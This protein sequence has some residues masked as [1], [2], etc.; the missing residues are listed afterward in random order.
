MSSDIEQATEAEKEKLENQAVGDALRNLTLNELA[1]LPLVEYERCRIEKAKTLGMRVRVLDEEVEQRKPK[2][3]SSATHQEGRSILLSDP[4]PWPDTVNLES[5]LDSILA[6]IRRFLILPKS[7]AVAI[8]LWVVHTYCH[9]A[10]N[11]SPILAINSPE[12]RCGKSTLVELLTAM[13]IRALPASNV[14]P[15]TIFRGIEAFHPTLLIDEADTFLNS[16]A[17]E[18]RGILNSGHRRSTALVLRTVGDAHEVKAFSTWCPKAI[19]AIGKLPET[20]ADRSVV[21]EMRRK[22]ADEKVAELRFD[23]V[24][25]ELEPLR[26]QMARWYEDNRHLLTTADPVMPSGIDDRAADNWRP[27]LAVADAA[28][29]DWGKLGRE[30]ATELC[31]ARDSDDESARTMLLSD[32]RLLFTER[33]SDKLPSEEIVKALTEMENRPWPEWKSGKPITAPQLAKLLKPFHIKSKNIRT[34]TG[35]PKGYTLDQFGDA[36]GRYLPPQSATPLQANNGKGLEDFSAATITRSVADKNT[37]KSDY[38]N[39]VAD[40]ADLKGVKG[41]RI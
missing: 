12:K 17:D 26:Q 27:L 7:A 33:G 37:G 6:A 41:K 25:A 5:V 1:A 4:E 22:S 8:T 32:I 3:K 14:T 21:I 40:V 30:A 16:D 2:A 18:L 28:G 35:V 34:L 38:V 9:D 11:V 39:D 36:F 20:L 29:S 24:T 15:A 19:A 10:A 23:R 13:V 31:G